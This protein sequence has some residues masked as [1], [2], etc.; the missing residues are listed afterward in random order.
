MI[1]I[2]VSNAIG[3]LD[4]KVGTLDTNSASRQDIVQSDA[5]GNH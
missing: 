5:R 2:V 1:N 4:T 3:K